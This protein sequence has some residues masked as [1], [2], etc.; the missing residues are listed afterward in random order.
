ML[1]E[2][3]GFVPHGPDGWHATGD[4]GFID[5]QGR[6]VLSGRVADVI[7]T[8]GYRVN[9]DEI[10]S[11]LADLKDA[12]AVCVTAIASDYWGEIIV[13]VAEGA[14]EGWQQS[15]LARLEGLSRHK[16]PRL[17]VALETLPRNAQGKLSR[18]EVARTLLAEYAL[19]DGPYPSLR[20][21]RP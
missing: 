8:G 6:L 20:P 19:Q 3:R 2:G 1:V 9:P 17:W 10:E 7:K 16:Q 5:A 15:A 12:A 18:R 4:L 21:N 13:A 11:R 14:R